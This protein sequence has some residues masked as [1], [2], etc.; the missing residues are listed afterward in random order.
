M[1]IFKVVRASNKSKP[2]QLLDV[3]VTA[4]EDLTVRTHPVVLRSV[5]CV[6]DYPNSA[7]YNYI[8]L[9]CTFPRSVSHSAT[10]GQHDRVSEC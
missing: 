7:I 1:F 10:A 4:L 3:V 5:R 9:Q 6:A 8:R 2:L